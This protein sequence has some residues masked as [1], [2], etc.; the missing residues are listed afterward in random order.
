MT[1]Q[2]DQWGKAI[3]QAH[4]LTRDAIQR[5]VIA[6][7]PEAT[8]TDLTSKK[9]RLNIA[10]GLTARGK[11]RKNMRWLS[12]VNGKHPDLAHL[13]KSSKEYKRIVSQRWR[14]A[15]PKGT[16]SGKR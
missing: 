15:H 12:D 11:P 2:L 3:L 16:S 10:A 1:P 9:Y 8:T 4:G 6:I 5:H 13:D 7:A 14:D